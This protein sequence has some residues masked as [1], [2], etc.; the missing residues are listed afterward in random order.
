MHNLHFKRFK[1][2]LHKRTELHKKCILYQMNLHLFYVNNNPFSFNN[3]DRTY[4]L[5]IGKLIKSRL[6]NVLK[7][8]R[9]RE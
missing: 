5:Q 6:N 9:N 3:D 1:L 7:L 2:I 8:D 4:V